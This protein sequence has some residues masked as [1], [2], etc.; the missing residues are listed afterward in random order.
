MKEINEEDANKELEK[1][2][3]KAE[4]LLKNEDKM[5]KFLRKLEKKLKVIPIAGNALSNI[6]IMISMIKNYVKKEYTEAPLGTIVAI[7]SA[8]IYF[9]APIDLIPD[10]FA[11]IGFADDAAVVAAC[12]K[13]I[14]DD[15]EEYKKWREA[16]GFGE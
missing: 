3:G 1:R 4:V 9:L 16:N 11:G 12:V 15:L 2:Y 10:F 14:Y 5:E 13:L 8:L 6:P 7:I